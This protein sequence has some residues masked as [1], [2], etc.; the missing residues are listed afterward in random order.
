MAEGV[1][2]EP[3]R[4]PGL[5][6]GREIRRLSLRRLDAMKPHVDALVSSILFPDDPVAGVAEIH[7]PCRAYRLT[8]ARK[9]C[10]LI[11]RNHPNGHVASTPLAQA[12]NRDRSTVVF[13]VRRYIEQLKD[14]HHQADRIAIQRICDGLA[15]KGFRPVKFEDLL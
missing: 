14:G 10:W 5:D 2:I 4:A 3:S 7:S 13:Q 8:R 6:Y 9:I 11:L 12:Y 1:S 15:K